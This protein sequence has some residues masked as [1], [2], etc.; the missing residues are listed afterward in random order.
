M[1]I[2]DERKRYLEA[3]SIQELIGIG[4]LLQTQIEDLNEEYK[5]TK[6]ILLK[7]MTKINAT[8]LQHSDILCEAKLDKTT[9][10]YSKLSKVRELIDAEDNKK[11]YYPQH[12]VTTMIPEVYDMRIGRGLKRYGDEVR[13]IIEEAT[14]SGKIK[15]VTLKHK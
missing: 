13:N 6:F 9:Y 1:S 10:N 14:E 12:E 3:K 8:I 5:Y 2:I 4:Y 11:F 15:D 7:E